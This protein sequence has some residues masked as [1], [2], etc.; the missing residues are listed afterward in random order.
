VAVSLGDCCA[1]VYDIVSRSF[2]P[3][4]RRWRFVRGL[5]S[6]GPMT[7]RPVLQDMP[8]NKRIKSCRRVGLTV[9]M[10]STATKQLCLGIPSNALGKSVTQRLS[11]S[12]NLRL[13]PMPF[14]RST[15]TITSFRRTGNPPG[16]FK[17]RVG[18]EVNNVRQGGQVVL[19]PARHAAK[20]RVSYRAF[21][22]KAHRGDNYGT[23]VRAC[24][25][26]ED[27]TDSAVYGLPAG[28]FYSSNRSIL[29]A[30]GTFMSHSLTYVGQTS[31]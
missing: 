30:S 20:Q 14:P 11:T 5:L 26:Y 24:F 8:R 1:F 31:R 27:E 10:Y 22:R 9:T 23:S 19:I 3:H 7:N 17:S 28:Y 12:I 18:Q 13:C 6:R 29:P 15:I 4:P 21:A 25:G 16:L 2:C